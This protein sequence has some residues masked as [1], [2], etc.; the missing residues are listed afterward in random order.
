M[1]KKDGDEREKKI[2]K[3]K[4]AMILFQIFLLSYF[5]SL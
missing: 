2:T 1:S 3:S 4:A 5:H